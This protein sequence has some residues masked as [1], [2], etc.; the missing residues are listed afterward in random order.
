M[1]GPLRPG[2]ERRHCFAWYGSRAATTAE[3]AALGIKARWSARQVEV[4]FLDGPE[5]LRERVRDAAELWLE[6][7]IGFRF[8]WRTN[9]TLT[10]I[11]ISFLHPGSWSMLGK[12]C[13]RLTDATLP[14]MNF[15]WLDVGTSDDDVRQVVLHEF[16]HALGLIHE[17]QSPAAGI[18]WAREQVIADLSGPPHQWSEAQ[19]DENMFKPFAANETNFTAPDPASI[20]MYPIPPH[21]T[22][23]GFS[24]GL[25]QHLS[26]L[27]RAF[28]RSVY[29]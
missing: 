18:S 15:G 19:I 21:W 22:T 27:D 12:D 13:L 16:G 17:H 1:A 20:M 8:I 28:I 25:N 14:T 23:N 7:G 29:P 6:T 4:S 26:A 3:R 10:P 9:T 11:R 2:I 5:S 24:V